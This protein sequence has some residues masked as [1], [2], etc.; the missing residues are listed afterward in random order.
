MPATV[1]GFGGSGL[2]GGFGW[3][4]EVHWMV[5]WVVLGGSLGGLIRW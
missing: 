4:E 2:V 3:F 5:Y 1:W